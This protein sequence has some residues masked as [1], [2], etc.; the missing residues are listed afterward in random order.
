[1]S[2]FLRIGVAFSVLCAIACGGGTVVSNVAL[3]TMPRGDQQRIAAIDAFGRRLFAALHDGRPGSVV[4][5]DAALHSVLTDDAATRATIH[6]SGLHQRIGNVE[7]ALRFN[8][9]HAHYVGLCAQG[10]RREVAFGPLGLLEDGWV[11]DRALV[12]GEDPQAGHIASW[13]EGNFIFTSE[14]FGAI[15]LERVESPRQEHSDLEIG[16]CDVRAG[17]TGYDR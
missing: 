9:R 13:V 2:R 10:S 11:I 14:G 3:V 5:G 16:S 8:F 15:S 12:V 17:F 7:E 6:R 1:M 4:L